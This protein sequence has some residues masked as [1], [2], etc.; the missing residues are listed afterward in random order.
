M[1]SK[2][3][4]PES[5]RINVKFG[6]TDIVFESKGSCA[7]VCAFSDRLN[8]E[9]INAEINKTGLIN[10]YFIAVLSHEVS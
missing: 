3:I 8:A 9:A 5:S 10:E 2:S 4:E 7:R 1:Q 6:L